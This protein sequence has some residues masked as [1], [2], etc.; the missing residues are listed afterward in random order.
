MRI[1]LLAHRIVSLVSLF[2]IIR[3]EFQSRPHP[4]MLGSLQ[5][6]AVLIPEQIGLFQHKHKLH[7]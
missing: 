5:T 4:H 7:V 6:L 2:E 3:P 1:T